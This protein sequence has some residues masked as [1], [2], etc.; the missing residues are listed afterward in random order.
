MIRIGV[1][2]DDLTGACDTA[3]QFVRA[4]WRTE[5]QIRHRR[6]HA[7]VIA[8][9]TGS[10]AL[11][12]RDAAEAVKASVD[13]LVAAGATRLYKKVDS[14]M[15]GHVRAELSAALTRWHSDAFAVVCPAFPAAGRL[16]IGGVLSVN[17]V[18]VSETAIG[19]DPVTPVTE[20]HIPTLLGGSHVVGKS[21]ESPQQ[22]AVRMRNA[23]PIVIADARS[24]DDLNRIADAV[25]FAGSAAIAVGSAG[26]ARHLAA[27][28]GDGRTVGV[29][30][31]V[32]TSAQPVGRAQIDTLR[33]AGARIWAT[34]PA[35]VLDDDRWNHSSARLLAE[36]A[37]S[38]I[39]V[40]S[41]PDVG[42]GDVPPTLIP[43]RFASLVA[44]I[45]GDDH[46][47]AGIVVTGGDAASAVVEA[48]NADGIN[49]QGEVVDGVPIGTI[50]GGP[51]EGIRIVTKAGGFGDEQTLIRA[52]EA[53]RT[54]GVRKS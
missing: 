44:R 6:T 5:L 21:G 28:W 45:I 30:I 15:R 4:G 47:V 14:T 20:S 11:A 9:S 1:V 10:R 26:L 29:V 22:F 53:I 36:I 52:A 50:V 12:E 39:V 31:V 19:R 16:V 23:G 49:L 41:A 51:A 46:E 8:L 2:A 13:R 34:S 37:H 43:A 3:V 18:N 42:D 24:D 54:W 40:M 38:G 25:A 27:R 7:E 17:G 35:E 32:V 33:R 48:L